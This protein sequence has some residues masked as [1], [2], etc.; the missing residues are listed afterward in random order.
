MRE[1]YELVRELAG[2]GKDATVLTLEKA[3]SVLRGYLTFLKKASVFFGIFL[4]FVALVFFFGA[5]F[6]SRPVKGLAVFLGGMAAFI[7][8]LAAFPIVWAVTKGLEWELLRRT[9]QVI[10]VVTL[11]ILFLSIYFYFI[12]VPLA[13]VPIVM[14][15]TAGIAIASV[16]F[17]VGISTRFIALRL[18]IVFTAMTVFFV[19]GSLFPGSFGGFGKLIVWFDKE[20]TEAIE[21]VTASL[22]QPVVYHDGLTFFDP[23]TQEPLIRY[24]RNESG[25]YEL[26]R[27]VKF[28]PVYGVELESVR[29]NNVREVQ[30]FFREKAKKDEADRL[31]RE[32]KKA[33]E[34]RLAD[35]ENLIKETK[36]GLAEVAKRPLVPGPQGPQGLSGPP[37]LAGPSGQAGPSGIAGASG[38]P[39]IPGVSGQVGPRGPAY[40]WVTIPAGTRIRVFLGRRISTEINNVGDRFSVE[41]DEPVIVD[42]R[43]VVAR[44]TLATGQ[45]TELKR[46]GRVRG[47]AALS[48][49]LVSISFEN[50]P[51]V[52]NTVEIETEPWVQSG[53]DTTARDALKIG[54]GTGIGAAAGALLGGRDGAAKGAAVGGG[55]TTAETLAV[56]GKDIVLPPEMKLEFRVAREVRLFEAVRER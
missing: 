22:P 15:L 27:G 43:T 46:P 41:V 26:F 2:L 12:P 3:R 14:T 1:F 50:G 32:K 42:D 56:R 25:E 17:G 16:I 20:T 49:K 21:E 44:R 23:R 51:L 36:T 34:Q 10:G 33:E 8:G 9:F 5:L 31:A 11:W 45:I 7:W 39:G 55:A 37:G 24:Y 30:R 47:V 38:P 28:H 35:L 40:E 52:G 19:L 29:Q 48:L 13:G 6:D 54:I 53:K 4:A 18:G